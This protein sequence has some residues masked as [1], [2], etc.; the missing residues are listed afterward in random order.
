[1]AM[2]LCKKNAKALQVLHSVYQGTLDPST[3][4]NQSPLREFQSPG[5]FFC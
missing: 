1:M 5:W 2:G 4:S 3:S